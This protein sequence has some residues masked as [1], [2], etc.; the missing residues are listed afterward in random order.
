MTNVIAQKPSVLVMMATYNGEK[1]VAEQI[2]SILAQEGVDVTLLISDDGSSDSTAEICNRIC[3][4]DNRVSFRKNKVN[5]KPAANFMNMVYEAN[6]C[7]YDYFAFSDQDDF[8]LSNKLSRAIEA[9]TASGIGPRLYYSDICNVDADLKGGEREYAVFRAFQYSLKLLMTINW[10]L[11]CTM[12]FNSEFCSVAQ[13]Y[14]PSNW[15]RIHDVWMH[16]IALSCGWSVPDLDSS[17]IKRRITGNNVVGSMNL[18]RFGS[19]R[20]KIAISTIFDLNP[21]HFSFKMAEELV[22]GYGDLI[23]ADN[24]EFLN[25]YRTGC[26]SFLKRVKFAFDPGFKGPYSV[27][28]FMFTIKMLLNAY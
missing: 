10:A 6:P 18:G 12:V 26:K 27:E 20:I 21:D 19:Q 2:D 13:R 1:Y 14:K 9:M 7:A 24:L 5:L 16:M 8:W 22:S 3:E 15:L 28:N 25:T 23:P 17:N 4:A 11:G